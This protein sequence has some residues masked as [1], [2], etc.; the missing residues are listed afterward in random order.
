MGERNSCMGEN[1]HMGETYV[2]ETEDEVRMCG[3]K[4]ER[5]GARVGHMREKEGVGVMECER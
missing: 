3:R 2:R 1:M 4:C 5:K